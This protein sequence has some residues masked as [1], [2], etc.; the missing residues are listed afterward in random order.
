VCRVRASLDP[1]VDEEQKIARLRRAA[2]GLSVIIVVTFS[3]TA[4]F[5]YYNCITER[6]AK[7]LLYG[8]PGKLEDNSARP[9]R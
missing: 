7:E 4:V 3:V 8:P 9:E 5:G 1:P 2:I 6:P